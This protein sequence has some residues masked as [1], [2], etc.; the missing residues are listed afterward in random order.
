MPAADFSGP[1]IHA[2]LILDRPDPIAKFFTGSILLH[3]AALA[4][5]L[6]APMVMPKPITL[7]SPTHGSGSVGV[8]VTKTIPLPQN[9]GP[10][11]R[12]ANDT[13]VAVPQRPS[14]KPVSK[15]VPKEKAP[16][17]DAIA[18]PTRTK[19]KKQKPQKQLERASSSPYTPDAPYK[20]NQI[21]GS[22]PQSMKSEQYGI[23]GTNGIGN[24]PQNPFGDR[25]G[26]YAGQLRDRIAQKW[27]R[28]GVT[29]PRNARA[30]VEFTLLRDGSVRDVKVIR[31]SG[32]YLLDTSAQRAVYDAAPLPPFPAGFPFSQV[33]YDLSF[34]L[35]Q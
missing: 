16:P 10:V 26:A 29:A 3:G 6:I 1:N 18:I 21:F 7:G 24:G 9:E 30:T 23:Q 14:P 27:N 4:V 35:E 13:K 17:K 31:P 28:S 2:D 22:T 33:I 12:V 19:D 5:V 25:Y 8:S 34:G 32:S 11:N 15:A 20:K